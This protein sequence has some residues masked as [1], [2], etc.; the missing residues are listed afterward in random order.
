MRTRQKKD[1]KRLHAFF[2]V[3]TQDSSPESPRKFL[4]LFLSIINDNNL[5]IVTFSYFPWRFTRLKSMKHGLSCIYGIKLGVLATFLSY[6]FQIRFC[7]IGNAFP[8]WRWFLIFLF[9]LCPYS[10]QQERHSIW[11]RDYL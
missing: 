4:L 10:L 7:H 11:H 1:P 5:T 6:V 3:S 9:D 8:R 2:C